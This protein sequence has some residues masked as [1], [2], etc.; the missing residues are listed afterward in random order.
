DN[1]E[2][3]IVAEAISQERMLKDLRYKDFA[4]LYRTNAQ[5]RA[6]GEALRKI[7]VPYK[8]YGGTSFYQR[9]EI[10][11]RIAYFR[12]TSNPNEVGAVQRVTQYP[13]R[14]I[15]DTSLD[16]ILVA[17]D[18]LQYPLWDVVA[19][20]SQFLDGRSANAVGNFGLMIQSFQAVAKTNSPFET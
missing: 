11:D 4:I 14:G 5:S 20:A 6:M 10:K 8:L 13:R 18:L 19:N 7:N 17:A 1:E 15:G 3:K 2:G 12:L 16:R 9:K